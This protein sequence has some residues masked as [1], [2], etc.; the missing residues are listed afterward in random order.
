MIVEEFR[1]ANNAAKR[2]DFS[3]LITFINSRL[4]ESFEERGEVVEY[5]ALEARREIYNAELPDGVCILTMGVDVQHNRLACGIW[6]WG[7]GLENWLIEYTE[8]WGDPRQGEVW[9]RIDDL[10]SRYWSYGNGR[11]LKISRTGVDTGD[12]NLSPQIMSYCNARKP[13]GVYAVKGQG[14]DR[15]PLVRPSKGARE[16]QLFLIGVDGIKADIM[17]WL[18]IDKPGDGY[19]HFP[20][21]KDDQPING[22]TTDFFTMLTAEKRVI[23]Q[24]KKGFS[25]YEWIKP[26]GARNEA[27][28]VFVYSRAAL[29]IMSFNDALMLKRIFLSVPWEAK[30][31]SETDKGG[32]DITLQE[33]NKPK[34]RVSLNVRARAA[35]IYL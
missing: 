24:D 27:L 33:R 10:L 22:C 12:G 4:C 8:F 13:K 5:H 14:G 35:G 20:I 19:C 1:E 17:S 18:R 23:R 29:R 15:I 32:I 21:G 26:A 6:G 7:L 25:K 3:L 9:N 28:D 34:K 11:K 31:A 2:N 16:R 30:A